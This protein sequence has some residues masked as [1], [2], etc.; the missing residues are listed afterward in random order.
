[1]RL[2]NKI[3]QFQLYQYIINKL[4]LIY[5]ALAILVSFSIIILQCPCSSL[6][7]CTIKFS[8]YTFLIIEP[9]VSKLSFTLQRLFYLCQ[10]VKLQ[11]FK[12]FIITHF[13]YCSTL[14]CYFPKGTLQKIYNTYNYIIS[15]LLN[16][17][18]IQLILTIL[19]F[20]LKNMVSITFSTDYLL[21][22]QLLYIKL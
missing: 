13:D 14:Y 3:I 7:Y 4:T 9:Y 11:F 16:L 15:K 18:A 8:I 2:R 12:S 10:S 21:E 17:N 1:M 19:M 5:I 22:W 20:F 6:S